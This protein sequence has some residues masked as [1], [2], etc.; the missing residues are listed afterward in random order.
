MIFKFNNAYLLDSIVI[1]G[2]LEAN[3]PIGMYLDNV[4]GISD[5]S[6][7]NN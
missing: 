4:V 3:G 7:E 6:F 1:G 2:N 5:D